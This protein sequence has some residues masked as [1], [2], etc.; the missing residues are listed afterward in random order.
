MPPTAIDQA[1]LKPIF[2]DF[3]PLTISAPVGGFFDSISATRVPGTPT[4]KVM[5][6]PAVN[7]NVRAGLRACPGRRLPPGARDTDVQDCPKTL[8]ADWGRE[9]FPMTRIPLDNHSPTPVRGWPSSPLPFQRG[10]SVKNPHSKVRVEFAGWASPTGRRWA[11]PTLLKN[12]FGM[13]VNASSVRRPCGSD[14]HR[15][16]GSRPR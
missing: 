1:A 3:F 11:V 10:T 4:E 6:N 12:L 14:S 13:R 16:P 8:K 9:D 7:K 2:S 15:W 5:M